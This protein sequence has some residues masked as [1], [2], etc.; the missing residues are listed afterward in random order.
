MYVIWSYLIGINLIS[1]ILMGI[2]KRR[3]REKKYRISE[4]TLW[5]WAIIGGALGGAV[6]MFYF[7]HKTKHLNFK[8]GF[9]ILAVIH[10]YLF[11]QWQYGS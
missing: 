6:G 5:L 11:I 9:P 7:R 4:Q 8:I 1:F 2:D 3:A 10:V